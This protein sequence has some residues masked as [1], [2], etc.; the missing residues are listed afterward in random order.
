M[1]ALNL[2]HLRLFHAV[3]LNG[4]LTGAARRLNLSASALSAQV[5]SLEATIGHDLFDRRG[6]GLVLTE[7]GRIALDHAE[8][9]FRTSEDLSATLKGRMRGGQVLRVGA[10]ATLSRN[11][12]MAFLR[13]VLGRAGVEV[14]LRAG[15]QAEMLRDLAA[16]ALD[17][18]L[19]DTPPPHDPDRRYLVHRIDA[20]PAALIGTPSRIGARIGAPVPMADLLAR[21]PVILPGPGSG[22]RAGF[23]TLIAT[24]GLTPRIVAEVDDMAMIRLLARAD[25]GLA[26]IAPIVVQDELASGQLAIAHRLPGIDETFLAVTLERRFPNPVAQEL[27]GLPA[28]LPS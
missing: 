12:Q 1:A 7:A 16:L 25:A 28:P 9:I 14:V 8:A 3:A 24:L 21:E 22:L 11:F 26:V 10:L 13:P 6:R 15:S 19:T 5:R 4:T 2:H 20:Q 23:D 18:V 17:V 27:C